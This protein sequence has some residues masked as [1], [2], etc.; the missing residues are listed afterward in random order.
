[1]TERFLRGR[2]L[3]RAVQSI[4]G[5]EIMKYIMYARSRFRERIEV[6]IVFG[7]EH[8]C[9]KILRVQKC[10]VASCT[11]IRKSVGNSCCL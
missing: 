5:M 11:E 10:L 3:S 1:M 6:A 8:L 4:L 9:D 2:K 7:L